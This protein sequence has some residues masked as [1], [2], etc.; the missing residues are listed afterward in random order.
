MDN[1][2]LE[3]DIRIGKA[4]LTNFIVPDDYTNEVTGFVNIAFTYTIHDPQ[5]S[6]SAGI[7]IE[8]SKYVGPVS[9][10]MRLITQKDGDLSKYFDVIDKN[11]N[12]TNDSSL[13]HILF[14]NHSKAKRRLIRG[15]LLLEYT[16]GFRKSFTKN[17]RAWNGTRITN[18]KQKTRYSIYNIR[19]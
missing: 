13:K 9:T 15:H 14:N 6:P 5:I 18:I 16:F 8:K 17:Q 19:G 10:N 12:T 1:G 2:Y 7:E 3:F 11:E 4:D